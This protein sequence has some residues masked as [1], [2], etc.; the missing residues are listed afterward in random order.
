MS[1]VWEVIRLVPAAVVGTALGWFF[2]HPPEWFLRAGDR[3]FGGE[4]DR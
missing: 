3:I 2:T 4:V 1:A